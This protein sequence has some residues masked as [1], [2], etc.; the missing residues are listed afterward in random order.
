M[1]PHSYALAPLLHYLYPKAR[2]QMV[3]LVIDA[4][5]GVIARYSSMIEACEHATRLGGA[6]EGFTVE[7]EVSK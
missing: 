1:A 5:L 2:F 6:S 7:C 4:L 3:Y